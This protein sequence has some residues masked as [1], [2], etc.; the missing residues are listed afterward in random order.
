[1]AGLGR[2]RVGSGVYDK[3]SEIGLVY[4]ALVLLKIMSRAPGWVGWHVIPQLAR[5]N[6]YQLDMI[7]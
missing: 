1:M 6:Q 4:T 2:G 5:Y 7:D 3:L